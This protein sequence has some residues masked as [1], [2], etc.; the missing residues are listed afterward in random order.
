MSDPNQE[1]QQPTPE[2]EAQTPVPPAEAPVAPTAVEAVAAAATDP[3]AAPT[4]AAPAQETPAAAAETAGTETGAAPAEA[5]AAAPAQPDLSP[6]ATGALLAQHFPAL[7]TPGQAKPIKLR[8]QSDI[9]ERVPGVFTKKSL[10]LFLHRHTTSTPYLKSLVA[11]PQRFD[12]DGQPA[13][14]V[15]AEHRDA[16]AA[17][18][19]R[20]RA[21]VMAKRQAERQAQRP[22]RA[23]SAGPA[24]EAGAPDAPRPP[25]G[26]RPPRPPRPDQPNR[27][28]RSPRGDRPRPGGEQP[29]GNRPPQTKGDRPPRHDRPA[30]PPRPPRPDR[31]Q[32]TERPPQESP[33]MPAVD[34]AVAALSAEEQ[35]ARRDR[36]L[37]LRAWET[38][39]LTRSNFCVLK[40]I[41]EADL[42]AQLTLARQERPA[43][44]GVKPGR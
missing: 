24:G 23:A 36:A 13:G 3:A 11:S 18:V 4:E 26:D 2:P 6:A 9:Q 44:V 30:Q 14:E 5:A 22:P 1:P 25:R 27:P 20:R 37:L 7:F 19:E 41:S 15:A 33:A 42:E 8:I 39:T 12:L 35:A 31:P 21:I 29:S 10:S 17:E 32:R 40:R 43:H 28:D 34:P 16:A 38:T